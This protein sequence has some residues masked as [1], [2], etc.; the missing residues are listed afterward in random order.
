[1]KG[2]VGDGSGT[3]GIKALVSRLNQVV[4]HKSLHVS[5]RNNDLCRNDSLMIRFFQIAGLP[6]LVEKDSN[7][8]V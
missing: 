8:R 7:L 3:N 6:V 2:H 4:T 5:I 1:M